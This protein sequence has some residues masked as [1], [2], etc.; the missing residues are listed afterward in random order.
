M[1]IM[2][3]GQGGYLIFI[4][5]KRICI[6]PYLSNSVEQNGA[7]IRRR[8]VPV[9]PE[10]LVAD[11]LICTHDHRDHLDPDTIT[12]IDLRKVRRI[13]GPGSCITKLAS[14]GIPSEYCK[15]FDRGS[16]LE[17]DEV[18][19]EAV[20]AIHTTDSIG[21]VFICPEITIYLTGD[22]L[23]DECLFSVKQYCPDILI[24]CING[25]LGNMNVHDAA[26]L[27]EG[28]DV[29]IAI[30][31]HYDMF[32]ENSEDPHHLCGMLNSEIQYMELPFARRVTLG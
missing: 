25:K 4:N 28:L 6:D 32:L 30:P 23:L 24:C 18:R 7:F 10:N 2:W 16:V 20:T 1:D 27:A 21:L 9:F 11:C 17:L 14:L 3:L 13:F 12:A 15:I 8:P 19:I 31:S 26:E 5:D 22:T 29:K